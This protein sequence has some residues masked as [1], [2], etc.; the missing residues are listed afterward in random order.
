MTDPRASSGISTLRLVLWPALVTLAVTLLRLVGELQQWSPRLFS[1][2]PGGRLALVGIIWL[3]PIFGVYFAGRLWRAGQGPRSVPRAL[4]IAILAFAVNIA[5]AAAALMAVKGP[6]GQ[7]ALFL[8]TSWVAIAV[9]RPAWP[10]LWRV[11]LVYAVSARLPVLLIMLASIF[12]GLD[13]HYAKPRPDF[14]EMGPWGVFFWT[15]LLPQGS[16]WFFLTIVGGL[17]FGAVAAF[18]LRAKA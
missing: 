18:F 3:V 7:L 14:P 4:G 17:I 6:V 1:R 12:G 8:V 9:A 16:I 13:T 5:L 15:A 10:A 2:E 11:L